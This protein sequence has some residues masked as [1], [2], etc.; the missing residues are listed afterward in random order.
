MAASKSTGRPWPFPL[1][2]VVAGSAPSWLLVSRKNACNSSIRGSERKSAHQA[3]SQPLS[4]AV[5][6]TY[7]LVVFQKTSGTCSTTCRRAPSEHSYCTI[8]GTALE[9]MVALSPHD[10]QLSPAFV[11]T[12]CRV[13]PRHQDPRQLK[14]QAGSVLK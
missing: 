7:S 8:E 11:V 12:G 10:C 6:V 2:P 4:H 3:T 5:A 13:V 14:C 1:S 9:A